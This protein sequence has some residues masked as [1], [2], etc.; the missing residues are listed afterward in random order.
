[1]LADTLPIRI[2]GVSD[3]LNKLDGMRAKFL[4]IPANTRMALDKLARIRRTMNRTDGQGVTVAQ[5]E[6]AQK[7]ENA[8]KRVQ[9]EWNTA[10]ERFSML[11]NLRRN[12][13]ALSMDG[14][15][16]AAQLVVS[17]GYV[18]KNA[19]KSIAAVDTLASKYLTADQRSQLGVQTAGTSSILPL[20]V[21]GAIGIALTMRRARR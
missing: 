6:E 16:I 12:Q 11:D 19:D 10:A 2:P 5:N 18:I 9:L 21:A 14:V 15:T 3:A 8:L 7:I 20:L 13:T 1:M 17:A 4:A